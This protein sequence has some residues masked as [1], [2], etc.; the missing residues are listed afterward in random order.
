M[1]TEETINVRSWEINSTAHFESVT[2]TLRNYPSIEGFCDTLPENR[3]PFV[4]LGLR[5]VKHK[6]YEQAKR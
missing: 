1:F 4:L 3:E 2:H 6:T 5:E